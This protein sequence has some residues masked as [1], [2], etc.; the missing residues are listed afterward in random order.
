M[1]CPGLS[2]GRLTMGRAIQ[3]V[4]SDGMP[5]TTVTERYGKRIAAA[6]SIKCTVTVI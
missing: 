3:L 5:S 1:S 4:G 2:F 6:S